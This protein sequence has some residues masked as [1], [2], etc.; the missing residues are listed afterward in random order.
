MKRLGV[1]HHKR[2]EEHSEYI[3]ELYARVTIIKAALNWLRKYMKSIKN[4]PDLSAQIH[5]HIE[6]YQLL[7]NN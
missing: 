1:H 6:Q 3:S 4:D 2:K 7:K 5:L